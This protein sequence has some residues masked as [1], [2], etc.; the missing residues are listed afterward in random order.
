MTYS[1]SATLAAS[2]RI[3]WRVEDL[4]GGERKLDFS[5]PFM[6]EALARVERLRFL[7]P[8]ERL[9]LNQIRGHEY[10]Y[11]FGL[12]EEFI[13][14]FVL[15]H[16]RLD[17]SVGDDSRTRAMLQFASEEAKHIHLFKRFREEFTRGFGHHIDAIGPPAEIAKAVL[18]HGTLGIAI[19]I[20]QIEWMS[21]AHYMESIQDDATL[22]PQFT[23]LLRHH[24][25]EEAQH[26]KLD[27]LLVESLVA[28][29]SPAEIQQGFDDYAKIGGLLDGGLTQQ[30][31][32]NLEAFTR[33]T[34][35]KLT[36]AEEAEFRS[37]QQQAMRWTYLGSGMVH[38][39]VAAT[40]TRISPT[41]RA[42][43]E[44]M[45]PTFS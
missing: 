5:R 37:V 1:Y 6:P 41:G 8:H 24:W 4:I 23:S 2:E 20:L 22:D 9:I 29:C 14:P 21:Q 10:L 27:T 16:T 13:L 30:L 3:R 7:T 11:L 12:V 42:A 34:G 18:A 31:Q 32:F 33:I 39:N 26:A 36:A 19:V 40:M 45:V 15:D 28:G 38:P 35:R 17:L 25:M 43:V 44:A